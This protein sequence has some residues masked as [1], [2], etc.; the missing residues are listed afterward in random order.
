MLPKP[1]RREEGRPVVLVDCRRMS[2]RSSLLAG[3]FTRTRSDARNMRP[4]PTA[5]AAS[6]TEPGDRGGSRRLA[7]PPLPLPPAEPR[8]ALPDGDD[9]A[10]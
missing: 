4:P 8:L 7:T 3:L 5:P 1:C 9:V 6:P 2:A 10:P